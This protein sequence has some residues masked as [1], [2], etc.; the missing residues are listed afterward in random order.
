MRTLHDIQRL[1]RWLRYLVIAVA[2]L[3]C[4]AVAVG[5]LVSGQWWVAVGDGAFNQ[6]WQSETLSHGVLS[7]VIAPL[8][9]MAVLMAYWLQK[10][11]GVFQ[12][13]EFFTDNSLRCFLWLV[14]LKLASFAYGMLWPWLLSA[15]PGASTDADISITVNVG[16]FFGLLLMVVIVHLLREAQ[17]ISSENKEFI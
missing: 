13:G 2:G 5:L 7:A 16:D 15:L 6:L 8:L 14:W 10:L 4:V 1:S 3:I 9:G 12:R 11:F 17:T